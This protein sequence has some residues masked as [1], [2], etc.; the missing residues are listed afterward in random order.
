MPLSFDKTPFS[1]EIKSR[2]LNLG[3]DACGISNIEPLDFDSNKY[4]EW[5]E[6]GYQA[7]MK[8]MER[9]MDKRFNP[10]LLV[11][12]AKSVISVLLNYF[13]EKQLP[14]HQY[15]KI[16]KYAYGIDYHYVIK[17]K[18]KKLMDFIIEA[19][20]EEI[21]MRAFVDS[22][23]V[24]DKSWAVKSGL[25]WIGKNSLLINKKF[26]SF[27][28][29]GEIILDLDLN[30]DNP[31]AKEY[32]GQCSACLD[33]CPTKA[34]ISPYIVD[35]QRCISYHTIETKEDIPQEIVEKLEGKIYGC[36]ICQDVCPWNS[37][38]S[39]HQIPEFKLSDTL[40]LMKKQDFENMEKPEFKKLF[41][42]SPQIRTGYKKFKKN[43]YQ[44]NL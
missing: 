29:V 44:A 31:L 24:L 10:K 6:K 23:P 15:Y 32:C 37:K 12:N 39:P 25:G 22:A 20:G 26:G 42:S 2:A 38:A 27:V 1:K 14:E 43:I 4:I 30:P 13:P 3:F 40:I 21:P 7:D 17:D 9:N 36:D 8:Y 19:I 28:F 34:I 5:I 41:K 35:S 18:L 33:S 11:E 16:S